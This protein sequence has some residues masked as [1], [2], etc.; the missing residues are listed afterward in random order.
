MGVNA[1]LRPLLVHSVAFSNGTSTFS[2]G[3]IVRSKW[4]NQ[5]G[6]LFGAS[7]F[8]GNG[9]ADIW[10]HEPITDTSLGNTWVAR[11]KPAVS[12]TA[13]PSP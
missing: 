13:A 10:C 11:A 8:D 9:T 5:R 2:D 7:D 4:C 12:A 3:G 6:S 1:L